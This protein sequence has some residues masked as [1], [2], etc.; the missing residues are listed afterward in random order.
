[1]TNKWGILKD[2]VNRAFDKLASLGLKIDAAEIAIRNDIRDVRTKIEDAAM[3]IEGDTS[4]LGQIAWDVSTI[5][6]IVRSIRDN[7]LAEDGGLAAV[8]IIPY[9]GDPTII[10]DGNVIA[11]NSV[12]HV[13]LDW[14][15]EDR[16]LNI[17]VEQ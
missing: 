16:D 6:G 1:M 3:K 7:N 13:S 10:R 11:S 2:N 15:R 8:V 9:R 17:E 4:K 5:K 12:K 14:Y